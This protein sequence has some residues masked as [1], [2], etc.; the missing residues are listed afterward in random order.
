MARH[1]LTIYL[2]AEEHSKIA[3]AAKASAISHSAYVVG[4]LMSDTADSQMPESALILEQLVKCR[5]LLEVLISV[6]PDRD[7][8]RNRTAKQTEKYMAAMQERLL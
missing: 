8:V 1:P 6:R 7:D 2:T 4:R 5:A 3:K